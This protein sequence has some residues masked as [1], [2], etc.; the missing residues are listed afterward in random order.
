M[1]R[2]LFLLC[3]LRADEVDRI[4]AEEMEKQKI[5]GVSIGVMRDGRIIKARGYGVANL[6]TGTPATVDT[7]YA[8]G[9]LSKAF[10]A[11]GIQILAQDGKL[12]V[13]D[14][15]AKHIDDL[16]MFWQPLT[17]RQLLTHTSGLVRESP[18][19]DGTRDPK[20]FELIRRTYP[21]PLA[22]VP[23]AKWQYS[24]IGYF[25][26]AE[27]IERVSGKP[28][29]V[30]LE[31][32]IFRPLNM[33]STRTTTHGELVT[34]RAA[35]YVRRENRFLNADPLLTVRP[36]GALLSNVIDLAKWDAALN[37]NEP[38][39]EASKAAAWTPI[40]LNSGE[41]YPYGLGWQV[42]GG[43]VSHGGALQGYK[44][45]FLRMRNERLSVVVLTNA[46]Q[47]EPGPVANRIAATYKPAR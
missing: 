8:I 2:L 26:L 24:N 20:L 41:T 7:V 35:S 4:V 25:V 33:E 30:F 6:E 16:P 46:Q 27:I 44:S 36:S 22:Y 23:G 37:T 5:P 10:V 31:E 28:W 18:A 14:R 43:T 47:A 9:S 32:R 39:T 38:L 1:I 42:N 29:A 19:F 21:V 15:L 34:N 12:N 3:V 11:A 13:D 45:H 17:I 40:R